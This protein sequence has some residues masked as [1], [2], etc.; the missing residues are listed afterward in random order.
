MTARTLIWDVTVMKMIVRLRSDN[1]FVT[2]C[3]CMYYS[4]LS[5]VIPLM[6]HVKLPQIKFDNDKYGIVE[7]LFHLLKKDFQRLKIMD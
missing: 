4:T 1:F 6:S 7:T 3:T 2:I 5:M